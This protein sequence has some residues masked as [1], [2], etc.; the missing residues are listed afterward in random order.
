MTQQTP[1]PPEQHTPEHQTWD[2]H[3][4]LE[5]LLQTT[6]EQFQ[7]TLLDQIVSSM[8]EQEFT[9]TY[10]HITRMHGLARDHQELAR[11]AQTPA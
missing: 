9:D 5:F 7:H 10:E 1:F 3:Q 2:R 4:K 8:S 6:T 11:H